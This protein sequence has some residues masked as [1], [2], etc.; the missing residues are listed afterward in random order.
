MGKRR[1][2]FLGLLLA[3]TFPFWTVIVDASENDV[4]RC[5]IGFGRNNNEEPRV[6]PQGWINDG[7]CD[8]PTTGEDEPLTSACSGIDYW[9]GRTG[10]NIPMAA[11]AE[12]DEEEEGGATDDDTSESK[13]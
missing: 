11:A 5:P 3:Q 6:I 10:S 2:Q 13:K 9:S 12:E 7:Y 1:L 8:C 4:I